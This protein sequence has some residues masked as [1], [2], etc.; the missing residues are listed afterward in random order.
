MLLH[1]VNHNF[2]VYLQDILLLRLIYVSLLNWSI[3]LIIMLFLVCQFHHLCVINCMIGIQV[4]RINTSWWL[5]VTVYWSDIK[6]IVYRT[7]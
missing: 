1:S 7:R 3:K 4:N 6:N 5:N 2:V